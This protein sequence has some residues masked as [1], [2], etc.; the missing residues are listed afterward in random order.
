MQGF[1]TRWKDETDFILG[2]TKEIWEDR[3][4]NTLTKYYADNIVV[5]S[6]ASVAVGNMDVI[7]ATMATL[8]EFPDRQLLG[9][10]VIWCNAPSSGFLSSHRL[11]STATHT[12]PGAYGEPTGR[13]L[14]YRIIADC[15]AKS[16]Q[17]D[18]EWLVRDQGAIVRQ[19]G[20]SPKDYAAQLIKDEGGTT[21][22]IP[23]LCPANDVSGPYQG[24]GNES[25]WG[26]RLSDILTRIAVA[27]F[28]VIASEYD[29]AATLH[30]PG[31]LDTQGHA[32]AD[33]FWLGL[34]AAFPKAE[35]NVHHV[36]GRDDPMMPPRAA[37]RW[38]LYGKHSGWGAFG[39][40]TGAEVYVLGMTHA[41]FGPRG[42]RQ[43]FTLIDEVSIWKQIMMQGD[44]SR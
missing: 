26:A 16:N 35:F 14:A 23:P 4:I 19:L 24:R 21:T 31:G 1:D 30:Y 36:I 6:P 3:G 27:D 5:R 42:L 38:S 40:P 18:D 39:R 17:I 32:G 44:R 11:V 8:A 22:C 25:H 15:H 37:A 7:G 34:H 33:Q 2:V 29:R 13:Q 10:D 41:E 43:E 12:H 20:V 9:E 28:A